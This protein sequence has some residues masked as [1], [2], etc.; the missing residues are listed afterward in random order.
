MKNTEI[1]RTAERVD[2]ISKSEIRNMTDECERRYGINLSQGV[3]DLPLSNIIRDAA[4]DAIRN[5][6]NSYTHHRG[7]KKLREAIARK[8][9]DFNQIPCDESNVV[10][11][12]GATGA[13]YCAMMATLSPGDEVVLFEPCY[14]YHVNTTYAIGAVPLYLRMHPPE[15]EIDFE[16]LEKIVSQKTKAI[17]INTPANPSGKIFS[18][19]EL[20]MLGRFCREHNLI[21]FTDEIY[22]HFTYDGKR[23]L[24]PAAV[25]ELS[26]RTITISGFSKVFSITGWR[27]GYCIAP[28][29][30]AE[31][32]GHVSDL[33]YVCAPAPLQAGVADALD[34]LDKHYYIR[35]SETY[36]AKRN[37]FCTGLS[38]AGL[39]PCKP[40]GAYYILADASRIPGNNSKEKA[41]CLL[42][43]TGVASVPGSAFFHEGNDNLLRFCF[44]KDDITL[45]SA[46]D[47]LSKINW[48]QQQ[49][50]DISPLNR[51]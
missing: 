33:I 20:E 29:E 2:F 9:E 4:C 10:V 42:D 48:N 40:Q 3:C 16:R 12:A 43:K 50:D 13:L 34:K 38:K 18:F 47:A 8:A 32:I 49:A 27:I 7:I 41:M 44:A 11:S 28:H 6:V 19:N 25:P 1:F 21:A 24:S 14:G 45:Q 35:L 15:W 26:D 36:Q 39:P 51:I 22:E 37:M 30:I 31:T 46:C 17:L 5:G 23:H